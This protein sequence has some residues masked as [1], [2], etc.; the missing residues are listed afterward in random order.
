MLAAAA[1]SMAPPVAERCRLVDEQEYFNPGKP[2]ETREA[3]G[4]ES[5]EYSYAYEGSVR[6]S[7]RIERKRVSVSM[8]RFTGE[9]PRQVKTCT[10]SFAIETG[11]YDEIAHLI[12]TALPADDPFFAQQR[13][14]GL[15][16]AARGCHVIH[17][18]TLTIRSERREIFDT[19]ICNSRGPLV[20]RAEPAID[21]LMKRHGGSM[22]E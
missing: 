3:P 17:G 15:H 21:A 14:S 22:S 11:E 16:S 7:I 19:T 10:Y 5:I 4:P 20:R 2:R 6:Q 13:Q 18:S 9:N 1:A 8:Y 12:D